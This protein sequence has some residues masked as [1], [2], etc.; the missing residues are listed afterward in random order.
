MSR[1]RRFNSINPATGDVVWEGTAASV[2][3]VNAAVERSRPAFRSWSQTPMHDRIACICQFA[4]VLISRKKDIAEAISLE[5]GKPTWEALAEVESMITKADY[6]LQAYSRRC[7]DFS[8][9]PAI[10]R[11]RPHGII[12]VFGPFN[13]PGHLPTGHILPALL[14]GNSVVF[15]PSEHAPFVAEIVLSAWLEAGLPRGVLQVIQGARSTGEALAN[16]PDIDGLFFTG[17]ERTGKS[18]ARL[19]ARTPGKI[20]AL[21]LG[22]NNP[23]VVWNVENVLAAAVHAA[24]S[25]FLTSGQRCTCARR[26]VVQADKRGDDF[27]EKFAQ[28]VSGI[29]IGIHTDRPEPFMGPV[30]TTAVARHIHAVRQELTDR[31]G[32]PLVEMNLLREGTGLITPGVID[33]THVENRE[34]RE[35]FGPLLQVIRVRNFSGAITEANRTR[36]GLAA[37]L[38]SDESGLFVKFRNEVRAG[39]VNWNHPTTGASGAAPFGGIG[40]SGNHRPSG[41]F[42]ADYCS[43]PVAGI[44]SPELKLST[45]LP[46][47][48]MC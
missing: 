7:A 20:L 25:A 8:H 33:V 37:G 41:F 19:L 46:P 24:Q 28:L 36:H 6:S 45:T 34:D 32:K 11:F 40:A 23:L 29:R 21:E 31:G 26:L 17:G 18:L 38:L 30:I 48:L 22:G 9:G 2:G 16:N 4:K 14:A 15:K 39:V 42:A 10:T 35:I 27:L 12:A 3:E 5:V 43:F 47:G 44:E 1:G 13:F